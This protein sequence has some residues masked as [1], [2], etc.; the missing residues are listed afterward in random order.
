MKRELTK[1]ELA[2]FGVPILGLLLGLVGYFALVSPQKSKASHLANEIT[3]VQAA[4]VAAHQ[5]PEKAVPVHAVQLFRLTK[6]M[7]DTNDVPGLLRDL[8]RVATASKVSIQ[9]ITP[10]AQ[11]PLSQGYGALPVNITAAGTYAQLSDFLQRLRSQVTVH[12]SN[13]KATG[14]LLIAKSLNLSTSDGSKL[15]ATIGIDAFVYG[16]V[17]PAPAPTTTTSG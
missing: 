7:P 3:G 17:A 8:S 14:R 13:V 12:G 9:S 5:K 10:S 2:L 16:V 4:L 6:A 11:V 15:Q 1:R